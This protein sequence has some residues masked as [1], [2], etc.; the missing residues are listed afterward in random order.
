[1]N[2]VIDLVDDDDDDDDDADDADDDDD[3]DAAE[4][5]LAEYKPTRD[6]YR[7]EVV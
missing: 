1:V 7:E 3:D 2:R 5:G 6:G 4:V